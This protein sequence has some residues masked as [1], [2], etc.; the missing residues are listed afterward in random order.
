MSDSL[1]EEGGP[2]RIRRTGHDEYQMNVSLPLDEDGMLG[3]ECVEESCSPAYFKIRPGT[4]I[5]EAQEIAYCPY[6][7]AESDPSSFHTRD[8]L[9]YAKDIATDE[10]SKGL[11][12]M[13]KKALGLGPSGHR[14]LD[15]GLISMELQYKSGRRSRVRRPE[16][17]E[18]RRDIRC[19]HCTLEHS[20]FGLAT[21]CPDC[22]Q[23]IF[24]EHVRAEFVP[25]LQILDE[26]PG[27]RDRLGPRVAAGDLENAL[28]DVV[29]IFEAVLKFITRRHLEASGR[30]GEELELV[31]PKKVKN[32]YQSIALAKE[33]YQKLVG[34]DLFSS[35]SEADQAKLASIFEKRHPITHNLGVVDRKY[36]AKVRSG[37]LEGRE[38]RV[39][40]DEVKSAADIALQTLESAYGRRR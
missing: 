40:I 25:I 32:R 33:T 15:G 11:D 18:L 10:A 28:E 8:Q 12:K 13:V 6:C 34:Q 36:L 20:V 1:F 23:D 16:E 22:G 14:K 38:I 24:A 29:S 5:Q 4:G 26:V 37:E 31:F 21:W 27:R 35:V 9:R 2:H 3:R 30:T 39:T 7:R 17:E 19:S